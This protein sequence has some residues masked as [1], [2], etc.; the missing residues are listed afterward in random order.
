MHP[1][2]YPLVMTPVLRTVCPGRGRCT[3]RASHCPNV[4][5]GPG[6][7]KGDGGRTGF[8][9]EGGHAA[10]QCPHGAGWR[11]RRAR[12]PGLM[13]LQWC[14]RG[15]QDAEYDPW[16][17]G[18]MPVITGGGGGGD[19]A[20]PR[21]QPPHPLGDSG[22]QLVGGWGL[23]RVQTR[24]VGPRDALGGGEVPPPPPTRA[25][26]LCPAT[27]ALMPSASLNGICNRQ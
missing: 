12:M 2:G 17:T 7:R 10:W 22:Q 16:P 21:T 14:G 23:V 4:C 24:R 20:G 9:E 27:V 26:S 8:E 18:V 3:G 5:G 25:P 15:C 1:W 6:R 13:P 19:S 11:P